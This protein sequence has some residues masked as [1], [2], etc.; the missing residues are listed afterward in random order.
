[1]V[2]SRELV[3]YDTIDGKSFWNRTD[4]EAHEESLPFESRFRHKFLSFTSD[5]YMISRSWTIE[6]LG[7][8]SEWVPEQEAGFLRSYSEGYYTTHTYVTK[9]I[10]GYGNMNDIAKYIEKYHLKHFKSGNVRV[11]LLNLKDFSETIVN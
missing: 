6:I 2:K 5:D 1:M 8:R 10:H 3:A 11:V 4:A 7:E 9:S